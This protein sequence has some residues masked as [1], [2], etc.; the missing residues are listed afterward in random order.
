MCAHHLGTLY[1]FKRQTFFNMSKV[2]HIMPNLPGISEFFFLL[3]YDIYIELGFQH[4]GA[5]VCYITSLAATDVKSIYKTVI[6][7]PPS[8]LL[9]LHPSSSS[10]PPPHPS[11]L[12]SP[13]HRHTVRSFPMTYHCLVRSVSNSYPSLRVSFHHEVK[14]KWIFIG[15]DAQEVRTSCSVTAKRKGRGE[16]P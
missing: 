15:P 11:F 8:F 12:L 4:L 7:F 9:P 3:C 5:S 1:Y 6:F 13:S 14:E 16:P 2:L 10:S